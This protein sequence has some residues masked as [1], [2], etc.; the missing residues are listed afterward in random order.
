MPRKIKAPIVFFKS[1]KGRGFGGYRSALD[2]HK[3][4]TMAGVFRP[5]RKSK[6]R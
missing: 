5:K 6:K 4:R 3:G 2:K 1:K